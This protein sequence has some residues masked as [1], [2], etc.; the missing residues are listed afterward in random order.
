MQE[1]QASANANRGR[2]KEKGSEEPF[3]DRLTA[4]HA[5]LLNAI[6]HDPAANATLDGF[7]AADP[8]RG[9]HAAAPIVILRLND[10]AVAGNG[11]ARVERSGLGRVSAE[12]DERCKC[13]SRKTNFTE[14]HS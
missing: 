8:A 4:N 13:D 6:P 9:S 7:P 1:F 12:A 11:A 5:A 10:M 2:P 14:S 3:R